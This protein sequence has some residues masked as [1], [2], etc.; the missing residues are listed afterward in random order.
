[1][2]PSTYTRV[3]F[4]ERP[5]GTINP[6]TTFRVVEAP[7]DLKPAEDEALVKVDYLSLDP[8]MRLWLKE[9]SDGY[10]PSLPVGA[11]MMGIGLGTVVEAGT[12]TGV[13]VGDHGRGWV[14]RRG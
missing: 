1:M 13:A 8:A 10:M 11:T 3:V 2:A 5:K 6:D 7:F 4:A 12:N 9:E 14:G